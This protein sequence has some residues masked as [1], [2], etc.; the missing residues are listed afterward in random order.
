[1]YGQHILEIQG[2]FWII[3][4]LF[5]DGMVRLKHPLIESL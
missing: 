1:L 5:G 2:V 4:S 3:T